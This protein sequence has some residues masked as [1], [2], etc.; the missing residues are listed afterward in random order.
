M[1]SQVLE[2]VLKEIMDNLNYDSSCVRIIKSNRP[3]LCDYQFDGA[4]KLA[5]MYHKS[6]M[7]IG[8]SIV[9]Y[10]NNL[11]DFNKYFEKVE[12][13]NPGFINIILSNE[14]INN[15][16][17]KMNENE[18]FNIKK[19]KEAETYV[20][21]YGGPNVAKPL[22]VG[23]MRTAIVGESI[24]RIIK[25]MGNNV[26]ADVHLGDYGLQIGQ[27]IYGILEDKISYDEIT[28]EYLE[29]TYPKI[30]TI[31][32]ENEE[33]KE[34]CAKITKDLQDGNEEYQKLFKIILEISGNDINI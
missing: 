5:G 6:P 14:F 28:L 21:D 27:V 25:Y 13:C 9:D 4:F 18:N 17:I 11:E 23:H 7:E 16:I 20:I 15:M 34:K 33:I 12:F 24:K 19:A 30:S 8:Q 10:I 3:D 31:C 26:I 29:M 32:K 2:Q 22:H 1:I